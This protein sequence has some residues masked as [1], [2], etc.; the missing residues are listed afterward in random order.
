VS[1][2]PCWLSPGRP[3]RHASCAGGCS[4]DARTAGQPRF[5][6]LRVDVSDDSG[7]SR[8][9]QVPLS[10]DVSDDLAYPP[11]KSCLA[12]PLGVRA[13]FILVYRG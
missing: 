13:H 5:G 7:G 1:V 10:R 12:I 2:M 8:P 3:C 11:S 6:A 4:A 9:F